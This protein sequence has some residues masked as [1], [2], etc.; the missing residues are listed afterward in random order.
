MRKIN[1]DTTS[2][3]FKIQ[4]RTENTAN[5]ARINYAHIVAIRVDQFSNNYYVES[6][7]ESAP[8]APNTVYDK[9]TNTYTAQAADHLIIGSISYK[10]GST[11]YSVGVKLLQGGAVNQSLLVEH[12]DST[13]YEACFM[14]AKASLSA[15]SVTDKIQ[16][17]G[18]STSA[19]VK[20]ARLISLQLPTQT[21]EVEFTGSSNTF[22]WTQLVW[23]VDSAWTAPSVTVTLQL[24][25]YNL[26][27]YPTSGDG[28][29]SYTSSATANTDE[30]K[31]QTITANPTYFRDGSGNWK[32]KVK[33]T[34]TTPTQFDIKA[35]LVKYE[36]TY[37]PPIVQYYLTV[38]TDP[39]GIVSISGEGWYNNATYVDLTAP[40][41]VPDEAG[42]G[43]ERYRFDSW[44]VDGGFVSG[45]PITVYMTAN[46]VAV[47]H[48]VKQYKLIM[49][50][51]FGTTSPSA[52]SYWYDTG[53]VVSISAT[54]PSAGGGEQYVWL[55]WAGTGAI[56]YTGTNNPA[57]IT[58]NSPITEAA[59]WRHEYRLTMATFNY[60]TMSPSAGDHWYE[61]GTAVPIQA[62]A[63]SVIEG[64]QY[65]WNGWT[66]TGTGSYTGMANPSSV[67]MNGPISETAFWTHQFLLTIKT[68]GLP[69][70]YPTKVYLA[71]SQVGTA[72]DSSSYAKW[73]DAEAST[74][75][76]GVDNT[77]SGASGTQYVFV[78]WVEDS[79]TSNPRASETMNAPKTFTASY[80]TQYQV[81]FAQ[82]GS[83]VAPTVTY[84]AETDPTETVPFSVWVKAG[85]QITYTYQDIVPG[86]IGVRY[87]LTSVTPASPQTVSGPMTI[88]GYYKTQYYL[89]VNTNP[90]EVLTLNPAA[91]SGEDWY[92]S[93]LTA[94]VNAVQNVDKVSGQSRYDFRS[95][96]GATPTGTGNQATVVMDAPKTATA[97]Y[98]LQ[99]YLTVTSP[100]GTAGGQG[101]KDDGATAY[102]TL[103]TNLV[104]HGNG[105]RRLFVKWNG[106]ASGTNYAQSNA[107]TMNGAKNAV[108]VWKTQY[109]FTLHTSG[110][111]VK[112]TN[113]YDGTTVLGTATDA[114]P[115]TA[116]YDQNTIIQLNIDT[117][118]MASPTRYVFTQWTGGASG[119]TRPLSVTMGTVKDIT[120]NYKTQHLLTVL[121]DPSGLTP[122]PSRNPV[123]EAESASSWWYDAGTSVTLTAQTVSGKS[124]SYWDVDGT[125][126]GSGVNPISVVM[127]APHTATAHYIDTPP[128]PSIDVQI[129]PLSGTVY[130]GDSV[131]FTSSVTGGTLPLSYQWYLDG[132][133]VS[134]ATGA[135]WTF[136]PPATGIYHVYLKVTDSLSHTA[137]SE[138]AIISVII[139]PPTGGY[140]ISMEKHAFTF[141]TA[142]YVMLLALFA[143]AVSLTKRKRK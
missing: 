17:Y 31:S 141:Q 55:G 61:A 125:S 65:I 139:E 138:T 50:T 108:A 68:S 78:E 118:I 75:T 101:W 89:T 66:G 20:N 33:G 105:T 62:F 122:Q 71:G 109:S 111:G 5:T 119:S 107:I 123:G 6:E 7:A 30:T 87:V 91:V 24:Y 86:A 85:T 25:N 81:T 80:K 98:Q 44:T 121:T 126:K 64:E 133:P 41:F 52:G 70:A 94:T 84:T 82:S 137:T 47:A 112:A 95:W 32:I 106:D 102:A 56:S 74:G 16:Y 37:T 39:D 1:L 129:T 96:T 142:M 34:K 26:G 14:M 27:Q 18:E 77:V 45:N 92:D 58:M 113:V 63:P 23:T 12:K 49:S 100:Y 99:Y 110:L 140:S 53:S 54:A 9:V 73:F 69:S 120:A 59:A 8:A 132:S 131:I 79:S 35:D 2:H 97:N 36:V 40:S 4:F 57:S 67:T 11:S 21:L 76:I 42:V 51:N 88:T 143:A 28:Y 93:G 29:I 104:D 127:S 19:R 10:S 83:A 128:P 72:S 43:G 115:F 134:G 103:N 136:N 117:P 130:L 3:T 38:D 46:H 48:Y 116:W 15:G 135:T 124:F 60:G 22:D 90:T 13:D 114:T